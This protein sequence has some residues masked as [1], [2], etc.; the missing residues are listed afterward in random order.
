[1]II[2]F[3]NMFT[4]MK[5]EQGQDQTLGV[6]CVPLLPLICFDSYKLSSHC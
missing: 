1:M 2:M 4:C 5:M 3:Q 6:A